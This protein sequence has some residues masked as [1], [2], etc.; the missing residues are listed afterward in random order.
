MAGLDPAIHA[1][2]V[3]AQ[4]VDARHDGG[5]M[6]SRQVKPQTAL[7]LREQRLDSG[8]NAQ[9]HLVRPVAGEQHQPDRQLRLQRQ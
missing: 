6:T 8:R 3:D 4:D 7:R 5:R 9:Q 1:F 2:K